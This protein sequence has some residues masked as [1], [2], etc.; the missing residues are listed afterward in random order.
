[1]CLAW[2]INTL[3]GVH[4]GWTGPALKILTSPSS[5]SSLTISTNEVILLSAVTV[6]GLV[7]GIVISGCVARRL[8]RKVLVVSSM[9][10]MF[11]FWTWSSLATAIWEVFYC[12][13]F[14]SLALGLYSVIF[15]FYVSE[16][17]SARNRDV[18]IALALIFT[19]FGTEMEYALGSL[20]NLALLSIVPALVSAVGLLSLYYTI[21]SPYYLMWRDRTEEAW[22]SLTMLYESADKAAIQS[23]YDELQ[24][25]VQS[26]R[27]SFLHAVLAPENRK[28]CVCVFFAN[29]L[30]YECGIGQLEEYASIILL[31]F[32]ESVSVDMALNVLGVGYVVS[33]LVSPLVVNWFGRRFLLIGGFFALAALQLVTGVC[34]YVES[35]NGNAVPYLPECIVVCGLVSRIVYAISVDPV[36][37]IL[38]GEMFPGKLKESGTCLLMVCMT[39]ATGVEKTFFLPVMYAFGVGCNFLVYSGV[40]FV[41]GVF[42]YFELV[43]TKGKTFSEI[44]KAYMR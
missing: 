14:C 38:R 13:F 11:V 44:R 27:V 30:A 24:E 36:A 40:A 41:G 31:P 9:M 16:I 26:H 37:H 39:V 34:F 17:T 18:F 12:R 22:K 15:C 8:G 5:A 21:E 25:E 42:T 32:G 4:L 35:A 10:M 7:L 6:C 43:E 1:M 29:V 2:I 23:A 19:T 3:Y 28:I 20:N 33:V